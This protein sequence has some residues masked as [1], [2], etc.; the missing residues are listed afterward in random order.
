MTPH[1]R[2]NGTA[3]PTTRGK[4]ARTWGA[5][6]TVLVRTLAQIGAIGYVARRLLA[7]PEDPTGR[8]RIWP[9]K[10][11]AFPVTVCY[12]IDKLRDTGCLHGRWLDLGCADGGYVSA[13]IEGGADAVVGVDPNADQIAEAR[14]RGLRAAEFVVAESE[15][16]PFADAAFDGVLLNEVFEHV[17]DE[18]ATLGEVYRVLKPGGTLAL[19]SPNRWY[20]LEGHGARIGHRTLNIPIPLLPY[21]PRR[22]GQRMMLARNYWPGEL[23][24]MVE[25]AGLLVERTTFL[26]PTFQQ[27]PVL[28]GVPL[29]AYLRAMPR[30]ERTPGLR[31]FAGLSTFVQAR[32]PPA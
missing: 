16:L 7:G 9:G 32:R 27:F 10:S 5:S 4:H 24:R 20:P 3:A 23:V 1:R 21:L 2:A 15:H 29:K 26:L 30:I 19:M 8:A 6:G 11:T 12:R 25:Q 13:M 28:R 22:L 14:G 31:R 17:G 18:R